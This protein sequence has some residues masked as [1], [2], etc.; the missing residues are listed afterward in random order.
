MPSMLELDEFNVSELDDNDFWLDD[1]RSSLEEGLVSLDELSAELSA[2]LEELCRASVFSS[3]QVPATSLV[4]A[5]NAMEQTKNKYLNWLIVV[6]LFC[7]P[8]C[9]FCPLAEK[10]VSSVDR[11]G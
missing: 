10:V 7:N 4:Q 9:L 2:T 11:P 6:L 8:F 1:K 5:K 3:S